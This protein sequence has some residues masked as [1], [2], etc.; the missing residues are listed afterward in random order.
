MGASSLRLGRAVVVQVRVRVFTCG[1]VEVCMRLQGIYF[2]NEHCGDLCR[3]VDLSRGFPE[4]GAD[5]PRLWGESHQSAK[6]GYK[7]TMILFLR[8][9]LE[10]KTMYETAIH[11]CL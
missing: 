2:I 4:Y 10:N 9:F 1:F 5:I 7:Y 8:P 3:I 6:K 11:L